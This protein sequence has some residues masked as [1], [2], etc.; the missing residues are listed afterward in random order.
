MGDFV[1]R[2]APTGRP[3]INRDQQVMLSSAGRAL[4]WKSDPEILPI[5]KGLLGLLS[6]V[7]RDVWVPLSRVVQT[8][9][10]EEVEVCASASRMFWVGLVD[11]E[12][13]TTRRSSADS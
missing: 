6:L 10:E 1:E 13:M 8:V 3:Q 9:D 4:R 2:V 7:E 11:V 5:D 12:G